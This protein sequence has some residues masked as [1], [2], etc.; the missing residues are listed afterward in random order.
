MAANLDNFNYFDFDEVGDYR[1]SPEFQTYRHLV[2]SV[3]SHEPRTI[4]EIHRALGD[5][6]IRQWTMDALE[7]VADK[8]S[9]IPCDLYTRRR[10]K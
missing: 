6:V 1:D 5:L 4:A 3:L 7:F 10:G 8:Q 2:E 9:A